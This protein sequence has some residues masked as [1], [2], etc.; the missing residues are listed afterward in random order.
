MKNNN[1]KRI[2]ILI[3][4]LFIIFI[5][6]FL[7]LI[8]YASKINKELDISM[9][10]KGAT[11]ISKIY[12]YDFEDRENRIGEIK[13]LSKEALFNNRSEYISIYEMPKN[14]IN[15]FVSI[16]DK[17]FYSHTGVD[18][19]RT[20][21][22]I[23]N[24]VANF[25]K[26]GFGGSTIT[27]Q[28]I[29]NITGNN[30]ITAKRKIDEII[31]AIDLEK[32]LS[33]NQI[34]ELYLNVVYLAENSY[35]VEA[36]SKMYFNK[37]AQNLNLAEC[38]SI[39]AI[40]QNPTKYDPYRHPENNKERRNIVLSEML[41]QGYITKEEYDEAREYE[42]IVNDNIDNENKSNVYSWYTEHLISD[43]TND[44]SKKY[45]L[46][47]NVA[48]A[49]I[50]RGGINI[51]SLIDP[52]VQNA[53]EEVYL[54]YSKYISP[55]SNGKYP[56]SAIVILDPKTADILAIVGGIGKK[57]SNLIFNRATN[58]KRPVGSAIKPL[59]VYAPALENDIITYSTVY[60]DTPIVLENKALWPKNSPNRYRGLMPISF[61]VERS[62]N[63]VAVK[64]LKDLGINNSV[65][66][67]E[68]LNIN[69]DRNNDKNLSSLGLG[70][71]TNGETLLNITNAYLPLANGGE[72][73][74][75]RSY[76]YVTDNYGNIILD[77]SVNE[78]KRVISEQTSYIM[79]KMLEN[80]VKFG[81]AK[82]ITL[83]NT[84]SVAGKTGTSSNNQD[85]W[86]IGYT[87]KFI[88]GVWSGFDTPAPIYSYTNQS[89]I[90]F[91]EVMKLIYENVEPTLFDAPEGIV[92]RIFCFDSGKII[93]KACEYDERGSREVIGYYK[94][95]ALP[96]E[97]CDIHKIV[98]IDKVS[99]KIATPRTPFW[100]RVKKAY[101][102]YERDKINNVTIEDSEH[103][104]PFIE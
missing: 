14:L 48:R 104:I 3:F 7:S 5:L 56:E 93:N 72:Y 101:L 66:F 40:V 42:I 28:L 39:A 24:Y 45:N 22:A 103:I 55:T 79:T 82:E 18:W 44:I 4:V 19:L 52:S 65:E 53:A 9:F 87:P 97:K 47:E 61:A 35:G 31:R 54:N 81:T 76:L 2:F 34:L 11:S 89:C 16:E 74:K 78:T 33:K 29:K 15:A 77:N 38:A 84:Q 99:N 90:M 63:T 58:A 20:G 25:G 6:I 17:R 21:R 41:K 43:V 59:S 37:E 100:R 26:S 83:K 46:S 80:V 98:Y 69:V 30:Q 60:D 12:Y 91:D 86:F 70:Q 32:K 8:I 71:L 62:V 92:E 85:K 96:N 57:N 10:A 36:A 1:K 102:N 68:K 95:N 64:V 49:W 88:C 51:Y 50:L 67:L 13:E 75:A 23:I 94:I 73:K 27:Q